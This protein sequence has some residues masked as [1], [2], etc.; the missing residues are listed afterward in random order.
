MAKSEPPVVHHNLA[1]LHCENAAVLQETLT[2][3]NLAEVPHQ[4]FGARALLVPQPYLDSVLEQLH[5]AGIF[6]PISGEVV[7]PTEAKP[8]EETE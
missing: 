3:L 8:V 2:V 4:E 6:P 5:Q 1:L 7:E